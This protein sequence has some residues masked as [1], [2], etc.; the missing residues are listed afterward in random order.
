MRYFTELLRKS[1][2]CLES[3]FPKY[4]YDVRLNMIQSSEEKNYESSDSSNV[5]IENNDV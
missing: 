3:Y 4:D 2:K 1:V 5:W